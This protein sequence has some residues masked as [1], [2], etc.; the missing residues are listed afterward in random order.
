MEFLGRLVVSDRRLL[1]S[2]RGGRAVGDSGGCGQSSLYPTSH[3]SDC[4][5]LSL[6]VP[7]C[8]YTES[9]YNIVQLTHCKPHSYC[10]NSYSKLRVVFPPPPLLFKQT[11]M[12]LSWAIE[13]ASYLPH[14]STSSKGQKYYYRKAA[15]YSGY[16][17]LHPPSDYHC[18]EN[19][20]H[21][22]AE[23]SNVEFV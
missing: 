10:K 11:F 8:N 20:N 15:F 3:C 7:P 17:K 5:Q 22:R 6:P 13:S 2:D 4:N 23:Y 16:P 14:K 12:Y 21:C 1:V 9:E 18:Y 19:E